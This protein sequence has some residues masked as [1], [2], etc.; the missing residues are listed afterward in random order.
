MN[1]QYRETENRISI[2]TKKSK[3]VSPH[4][5][6]ALEIVYVL[7]GTVELGIG[8]EMFHMEKGSLSIVFPNT[9][10]HFQVFS[11]GINQAC[12][13][14]IP[15]G[16]CGV[17]ADQLRKWV[18][19]YPIIHREL[20]DE[21]MMFI[22]KRLSNTKSEEHTIAQA[23]IQVL[24]AKCLPNFEKV[25]KTFFEHDDLVYRTVM[26]MSSN[27]MNVVSLERMAKDL[28]VSKC[29]LSRVFSKTF[30][31]NFNQYLNDVRL[32]N[33]VNCLE[34]TKKSITEICYESGF[35][36]QRTF[37]RVFRERYHMTPS[38]YRKNTLDNI[39]DSDKGEI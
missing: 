4:L 36:S 7:Q 1:I 5:H 12:Y 2:I 33:A 3:H 16:L 32:C 31:C 13:I 25:E 19:K 20:F 30:H 8:Q 6:D 38:Q 34:C 23:Y 35:E 29:M 18:P 37:N 26:Y 21:E 15:L 28:C 10:H 27:Y 22:M 24:L 14:Q 11:K 9:I 17:F 39:L